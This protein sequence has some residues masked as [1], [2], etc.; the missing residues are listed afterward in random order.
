MSNIKKNNVICIFFEVFLH[1]ICIFFEVIRTKPLIIYGT[2]QVGKTYLV[3]GF[4]KDN[5]DYLYEINFEFNKNAKDL[6]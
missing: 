1:T 3:R 5:Y 4:A 6:F 2:R